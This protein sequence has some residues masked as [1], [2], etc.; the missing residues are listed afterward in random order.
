MSP[1]EGREGGRMLHYLAWLPSSDATCLNLWKF[2]VAPSQFT[3]SLSHTGCRLLTRP[4][5]PVE[6]LSERPIGHLCKC[7]WMLSNM[8]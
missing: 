5:N 8:G 2:Y 4:Q 1:M 7:A 3:A 6:M